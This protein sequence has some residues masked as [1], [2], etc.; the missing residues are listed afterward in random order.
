MTPAAVSALLILAAFAGFC[1]YTLAHCI[2]I[3]RKNR[4]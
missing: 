2:R 3:Y 4:Q 1:L